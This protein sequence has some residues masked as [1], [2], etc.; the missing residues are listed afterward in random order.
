MKIKELRIDVFGGIRDK[1]IDF[2]DGLNLIVGEN[3][4]GKS[5]TLLFIKFMLYGMPRKGHEDRERSVSR[6]EHCARGSMTVSFEGEE[7]RIERSFTE[8]GRGGSEKKSFYRLSDGVEAFGDRQPWEVLLGVPREVFESSALVGQMRTLIEEGKKGSDAIRNLLSS[9]D[10][11]ADLTKIEDKL[12]KI[13]VGYRHKSGKGGRL[14]TLSEEIHRAK[15]AYEKAVSDRVRLNELEEKSRHYHEEY[16]KVESR[17]EEANGVMTR[18]HQRGVLARFD[19]LRKRKG[20]LRTLEQTRDALLEESLLTE[21]MPKS[22]DAER[23]R[24]LADRLEEAE[25]ARAGA[26]A[27]MEEL[28]APPVDEDAASFGEELWKDGGAESVLLAADRLRGKKRGFCIFGWILALGSIAGIWFSLTEWEELSFLLG[29][30]AALLVGAILIWRGFAARRCLKEL[31]ASYGARPSQLAEYLRFCEN[32]YLQS[33]TY[34]EALAERRAALRLAESTVKK[35]EDRLL[36]ELSKTLPDEELLVTA[37]EGRREADRLSA[38]LSE[39]AVMDNKRTILCTQIGEEEQALSTYDEESLRREAREEETLPDPKRAEFE[40]RFLKEQREQL[41]RKMDSTDVER[42]SLGATVQ[43]PMPLAD[44]LR[45]LS[46][47]YDRAEEYNEALE[48]AIEAL[49]EAGQTMSGSV[50]PILGKRAGEMMEL[51]SGG[52]Y[53]HLFAGGDFMPSLEEAG[54]RRVP[55]ELLSGGTR[56]AAYLCLRLSLM[57]RIYEGELPPLMMDESL[58]QLDGV[59]MGRTLSLLGRLC[60]NH[61]QCL[62]FTCHGREAEYCRETGIPFTEISF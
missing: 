31:A 36:E 43:D 6:E 38:F 44:R 28:G 3:E 54:G 60:E 35:A 5:T 51:L 10:E 42:I 47:E 61:F 18:L 4:S 45:I 39:L 25:E 12:D 15:T 13:R 14:P 55:T 23:L 22:A 17:L 56:D 53:S 40:Q 26:E 11:S 48:L 8:S 52:R 2:S 46:A 16:E 21:Y 41:R 24:V 62:L 33:R 50:T 30:V 1:K 27:T 9:A 34:S 49:H 37:E 19:T 59:R 32:T 58:C 20:E 29:S 7:Y 57:L